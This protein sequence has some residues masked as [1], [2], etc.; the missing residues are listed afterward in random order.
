MGTQRRL[1]I[2]VG[3][4]SPSIIKYLQP[5]T[6]RL[7]DAFTDAKKVT[8]SHLPAKSSPARLEILVVTPNKNIASDSQVHRKHGRPLGSKDT[9]SRKRKEH[10]RCKKDVEVSNTNVNEGE[11]PKEPLP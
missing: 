6:D 5:L 9:V 10:A 8:K 3:F 1:R 7:P 11:T 2:Y 4:E